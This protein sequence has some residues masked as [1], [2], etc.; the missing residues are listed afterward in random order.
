MAW[1]DYSSI[2]KKTYEKLKKYGFTATLKRTVPGSGPS[3]N[4][5]PPVEAEFPILALFETYSDRM[6]DGTTILHGDRKVLIS[7]EHFEAFPRTTDKLIAE[8]VEYNIINVSPLAP[9]GV[10]ILYTL[11]IRGAAS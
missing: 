5:G 8:G 1:Y 4:P 7:A 11:Q 3:W 6:I 2:R 10:S 9:G